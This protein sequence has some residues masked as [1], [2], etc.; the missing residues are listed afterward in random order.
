MGEVL[1]AAGQFGMLIIMARL[2]SEAALG[3]YALGL[4][5]ATPM[6]VLTSLHLRPTFVVSSKDRFNFGDYMGLRLIGAPLAVVISMVWSALAG[7]DSTTWTMVAFVALTRLSELVS[8]ILHAAPARAEV[9]RPVGI[10]RGL[11]G[12]TLIGS[13]ALALG[14]GAS[15]PA[16]MGCGAIV[17]TVVTIAYDLPMARRYEPV[18]PRFSAA[19]LGGLIWLAAPV[20]MAGALLG[21]TTNTPAYVLEQA[22]GVATLGRYT[23][24]I[25]VIYISGVLNMAVGSAAVPRLARTFSEDPREFSR[26]LARIVAAV[27]VLNGCVLVGCAV[28]G[29]LY[30]GIAYGSA[31]ESLQ[32]E[33]ITAGGIAVG[34]GI[35]NLLSQTVVATRRFRLQFMINVATFTAA[36][37]FALVLVP[38]HGLV[39]ALAALGAT[40]ALRLL[41]YVVTVTTLA[42]ARLRGSIV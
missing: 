7:H 10:S 20:G 9:L 30:L 22:S 32:P 40:T 38:M 34:A 18:Q 21:L 39:G 12:V 26:L 36:L 17:G 31:F 11:R 13:V 41:I 28:L 16:A 29:R 6:F 37:V 5:I 14:L 27:A 15:P 4:A 2:G 42:R 19:K 25:S 24:V 23:A 35:A 3:Q 1:F 33:L 8:D